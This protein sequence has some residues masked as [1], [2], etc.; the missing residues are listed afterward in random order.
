MNCCG[1]VGSAGEALIGDGTLVVRAKS[2]PDGAGMVP[3]A[4]PTMPGAVQEASE[5]DAAREDAL[6]L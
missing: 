4:A 1:R 6:F 5:R 2:M 3:L